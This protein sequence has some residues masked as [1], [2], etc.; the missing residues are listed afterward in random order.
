MASPRP[1][2]VLAASALLMSRVALG[3]PPTHTVSEALRVEANECFDEAL[4]APVLSRWLQRD[5]VDRRIEVEIVGE[6]GSSEGLVLRVLRDG[7]IAGERRFPVLS[8]PCD[9]VRA[10]VGLAAALA[11]DATVLESL[12]VRAAPVSDDG[13][14]RP[15]RPAPSP[16]PG[17]AASVDAVGLFGVLSAPAVGISPALSLH[18]AAPLELRASALITGS[19][20]LSFDGRTFDLTL[21]SGAVDACGLASWRALRARGCFGL[22]AG[23][24]LA[25]AAAGTPSASQP[26]PWGAAIGRADLRVSLSSWFGLVAGGDLLVPITRP[27]FQI[28]GAMGAMGASAGLPAIG[29]AMRIGPEI[30]FR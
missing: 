13:D 17:V 22:A 9:D 19:S 11:I 18:V 21:V 6:P 29:A 16:W 12:G 5:R 8:A 10:A 2:L 30:T 24:L 4:L 28:L 14:A 3:A 23:R 26:A 25:V 15:A 1:A 27:R 20:R 7:V